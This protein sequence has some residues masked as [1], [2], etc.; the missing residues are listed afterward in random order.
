MPRCKSLI[1]A[2]GGQRQ[3]KSQASLVCTV[4]PRTGR[5]IERELV[6]KTTSTVIIIIINK[7][8]THNYANVR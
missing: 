2:L 4:S 1:P 7:G 3:V 8:K 5:L 6:F